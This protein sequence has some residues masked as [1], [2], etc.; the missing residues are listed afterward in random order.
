MARA[1]VLMEIMH[2]VQSPLLTYIQLLSLSHEIRS[3]V[4]GTLLEMS[5]GN[6]LPPLTADALAALV[7]PCKN[8][9]K[10]AL[11]QGYSF[12]FEQSMSLFECG[13]TEAEAAPWVDEAFAGHIHLTSLE[14]PTPHVLLHAL[15]RILSHLPG[16]EELRLFSVPPTDPEAVRCNPDPSIP[17]ADLAALLAAL[18]SCPRLRALH[19]G[20]HEE[21]T[22]PVIKQEPKK[23]AKK[24]KKGKK[25]KKAATAEEL[26]PPPPRGFAGLLP[27]L[28]GSL[29]ELDLPKA[30]VTPGLAALLG[31]LTRLERLTLCD[32]PEPAVLQALAAR[33]TRLTL[34][35][36]S[37]DVPPFDAAFGRLEHLTVTSGKL[38]ARPPPGLRSFT[39]Q[40]DLEILARLPHL[41]HLNLHARIDLAAL[42]QT[43]L[44]RLE[45][46]TL[47][48]RCE[49]T[50]PVRLASR[51]LRELV[52]GEG[53]GSHVCLGPE[54]TLTL[55]CPALEVVTLPDSTQQQPPY[56][57]VLDCPRLRQIIGMNVRSL[58]ILTP[59]PD[60]EQ[61]ACLTM[62]PFSEP[63]WVDSAD[64]LPV[65]LAGSPRLWRLSA[66]V[67]TRP[68]ALERLWRE[69]RALTHLD[70]RL[71]LTQFSSQP[72]L[73]IPAQIQSLGLRLA[74]KAPPR[75]LPPY[76]MPLFGGGDVF[77]QIEAP[78]LRT[79]ALTE[80]P[81]DFHIG[82][83]QFQ[84]DMMAICMGMTNPRLS[85]TL[86]CPALTEL[87]FSRPWRS[88]TFGHLDAL[89]I[90]GGSDAPLP[91]RTLLVGGGCFSMPADLLLQ[92]LDIHGANLRRVHLT[93][94]SEECQAAW[95]TLAR[96]LGRLPRLA[97]LEFDSHPGAEVELSCPHLRQLAFCC[98][99][100]TWDCG[101]NHE[102]TLTSM[103]LDCPLLEELQGPFGESLETF[104]LA[105][106]APHLRRIEGVGG[107]WVDRLAE[108]FPHAQ[109]TPGGTR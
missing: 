2:A 87:R 64:W 79:L 3:I 30:K 109:L 73:R 25:G 68:A 19:L 35:G 15:P 31:G 65:L 44:D 33:L 107:E 76:M 63:A 71:D 99:D 54:A 89:R 106:E 6:D 40:A 48:T 18:R 92:L 32:T 102:I 60:L 84:L 12:D 86:R 26:P 50:R 45:S 29:Q 58:Q 8:L 38:A 69:G 34:T 9:Q 95:P 77:L 67:I 13:R 98:N 91:L 27:L 10:L 4:R 66:L 42:P 41:V 104:E 96:A 82:G 53:Q 5:F 49:C 11:P 37:T 17:A 83:G 88:W 46:L 108:R 28:A 1:A 56:A 81:V 93:V 75:G 14:I 100:S 70:L 22:E 43:L 24:G 20:E 80:R 61:V 101:K 105:G 94:L 103:V 74:F 21:P 62:Y 16:L 78:G 85:L 72:T 39:G 51:S 97:S 59:M 36:Y 47:S 23:K 52:M 57:L 7:G 90:A 55:A